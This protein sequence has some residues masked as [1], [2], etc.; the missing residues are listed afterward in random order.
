MLFLQFL[1][2][3]PTWPCSISLKPATARCNT[4]RL[5]TF[6]IHIHIVSKKLEGKTQSRY[7]GKS[8][9]KV[10]DIFT[11]STDSN[12]F[13][14]S[15]TSAKSDGKLCYWQR[16]SWV[17]LRF[18]H[19]VY[20]PRIRMKIDR[21]NFQSSAN[22]P[23]SFGELSSSALPHCSVLWMST[24]CPP[25][26]A[27]YLFLAALLRLFALFNLFQ[28]CVCLYFLIPNHNSSWRHNSTNSRENTHGLENFAQFIY[29]P[30]IFKVHLFP[31]KW[32]NF[33]NI[34]G[35][36]EKNASNTRFLSNF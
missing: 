29:D 34:R 23:N 31:S 19:L 28:L 7:H 15:S 27:L 20:N 12:I 21:W 26:F 24:H 16:H 3:I 35:I 14:F 25:F 8:R 17:K 30:S 32:M 9:M 22:S 10:A 11:P 13:L 6:D 18:W 4:T 5:D 1:P 2:T 36:S 33:P